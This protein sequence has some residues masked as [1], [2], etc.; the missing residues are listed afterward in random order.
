MR[1][2]A[3]ALAACAALAL[4]FL[5]V[6]FWNATRP[7]E[8]VKLRLPLEGLPAGREIRVLHITDTHYG[9]PDMRTRRLNRIVS[10]ANALKPDLI[11]LT[12]DYMG[13]KL[14]DKPRSWLEEALPPLAALEAPLGVYAVLGNHD[15]PKWTPVVM[16]RQ[17][18]PKLLVNAHVDIGPLVVVGLNSATHGADPGKALEG[19]SPKRPILLLIHE[20]DFL[21]YAAR[22]P[23]PVLALAGHTHGGQV[24]LPL[25]GSLGDLHGGKPLCLRGFCT[26]NGWPLFVSSG[27]GTTLL[28]IR[29]GVPPEIVEISLYSTGR[30]SGTER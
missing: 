20:G 27:V 7:P 5:G 9:Y 8:V 15:E 19:I 13:G 26:V 1:L 30:N 18:A 3:R 4:L 29:Y 22:P 2:L 12:G 24:I 10:Q 28:P 17:T 6:G 14:F 23:N 21:T 11:V 25:I 16:A